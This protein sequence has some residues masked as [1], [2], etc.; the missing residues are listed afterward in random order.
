MFYVTFTTIKTFFKMQC[1]FIILK[2]RDGCMVTSFMFHNLHK[3]YIYSFI[4]IKYFK[5]KLIYLKIKKLSMN[6][7]CPGAL[8]SILLPITLWTTFRVDE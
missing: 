1:Y 6:F 8:K 5:I 7:L 4:S 2:V 3:H